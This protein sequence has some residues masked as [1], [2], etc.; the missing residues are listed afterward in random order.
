MLPTGAQVVTRVDP[1]H[2]AGNVARP[3]G[4]V[5]VIVASPADARH[6]YRVRFADGAEA[7]LR[8]SELSIRAAPNAKCPMPCYNLERLYLTK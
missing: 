6:A 7:S 4:A 5:G 3:R 2:A 8:R 1:R